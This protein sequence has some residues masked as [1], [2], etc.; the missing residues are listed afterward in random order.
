MKKLFYIILTLF[1]T[2]TLA[3]CAEGEE[4]PAPPPAPPSEEAGGQLPQEE[5]EYPE[6]LDL[7]VEET[8]IEEPTEE[9]PTRDEAPTPSSYGTPI[10]FPGTAMIDFAGEGDLAGHPQA[11]RF[12]WVDYGIWMMFHFEVPVEDLAFVLI[13]NVDFDEDAGLPLYEINEVV[14]EAGNLAAGQPFFVQ[15]I[16]HFGTMPGQAIGFTYADGIRYYIPFDQSQMDG[17]LVLHKWAAFTC[18]G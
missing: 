5:P 9:P 2:L 7:Q 10:P 8:P 13:S 12:S 3:A 15:T 16:G 18:Y 1:L 6:P 17:S 14:Y 11:L 4:P